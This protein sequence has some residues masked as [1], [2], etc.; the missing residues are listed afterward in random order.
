MNRKEAEVLELIRQNPFMPQQE[1]A[2]RLGVSRPTLANLISAL[3]REGKVLGRAYILPQKK[4]VVCIGGANVDRKFRLSEPVKMGTSNPA[5]VTKSIG[6]V[7]RNVAENLGRL[8]HAVK[9]LSVAGRDSDWQLIEEASAPFMGLELTSTVEGQSTGSYTAVLQPDGDMVLAMADMDIFKQLTPDHLARHESTLL[10]AALLVMDL[11]CPKESIDYI[12][13]MAVSRQIPLAVIAVSAP[14]MSHLGNELIGLAYLICNLS[15][16]E[17]YLKKPIQTDDEWRNAV[18]QLMTRGAETVII[19]AGNR[20]VMA[21]TGGKV[22][23]FLALPTGFIQDVTGAG[24]A[25]SAAIIHG[26]LTGLPFHDVIRSGLVNAR[27]TLQSPATVRPELNA[28]VLQKELE[29][30]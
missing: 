11:N 29:E 19:T 8:D 23:H 18:N 14:K 21:G 4:T 16:A 20:G 3:T 2:D 17:A 10:S 25:F 15:E 7:A 12:R 6:G 5:S 27:K 28:A 30:V 26:I 24:D 22:E 9:L 13:E 1:M